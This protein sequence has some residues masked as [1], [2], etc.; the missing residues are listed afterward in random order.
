MNKKGALMHWV[1]LGVLAALGFFFL[2]M[3]SFD[4]GQDQVGEWQKDFLANY[5]YMAEARLVGEQTVIND[6]GSRAWQELAGK[7]IS[8]SELDCGNVE[9]AVLWNK[10]EKWCPA[11]YRKSMEEVFPLKLQEKRMGKYS[12]IRRV[13]DKIILVGG[14]EKI[15]SKEGYKLSYTYQRSFSL[16][17]EPFSAEYRELLAEGQ[18]IVK[19]C[20]EAVKLDICWKNEKKENWHY[21]SCSEEKDIPAGS[22][23]IK[24]CVQ[25]VEG[26]YIFGLDFSSQAAATE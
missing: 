24:I 23:V 9:G 11:D 14:E 16:E 10:K 17:L 4:S 7:G 12:D 21:L 25:G 20:N 6:A 8:R 13:G 5:V 19:I 18:R 22:T 1:V 3:A 26:Q 15:E 2:Q